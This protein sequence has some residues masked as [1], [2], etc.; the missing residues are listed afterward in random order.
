MDLPLIQRRNLNLP[1]LLMLT[2]GAVAAFLVIYPMLNLILGSLRTA[3][4][5]EPGSFTLKNYIDAFTSH[6]I[7]PT[8]INTFLIMI[9][10]TLVSC[11]VGILLVW[12]TTR[13]DTPFRRQL[14]VLNILPFLLSPYVAG[15]AWS[16]LLS[17]RIGVL[18]KFLMSL[19][20]LE[21]APF[22]IFTISGVIW[23]L[24]LYYTPYMYLFILGSF[25]AMDPSMEE[26]ARI[27]GS[28]LFKTTLKITIP[29]AAPAII[30][31]CIIV[32]VHCAGQFGVPAH[33][34][35]PKGQ[36]VL[37][38]TIMR[39]TQVYPQQYN[40]AAAVSMLLL[41]IS[42]VGIFMQR[43][44]IKGRE[45]TTVTGK[46]FRPRLILLGRWKYATLSFNI[47]YLI[48]SIVFPYGTLLVVSFLSYWSGDISTEMLTMENYR[49]VLF[50]DEAI[51]RAIKN[52][53]FVSTVG[54]FLCL[55]MTMLV[56]YLVNRT[57]VRGRGFFDYITM[58]PVGIP[59]MVVAVGL[60]WAWIRSPIPVYGTIWIIMI[61]FIT[62]YIPYGM[63]AFSNSLLQLGPELEESARICGSSWFKTFMKILI[64]LLKPGFMAGWVL[65]FI[66]FMRELSTAIV[67]WYSGNEVISVQL[68]Q[69]V[70][71]GEFTAVAALSIIQAL[72]IL[73][74]IMLFRLIVKEEFS[75]RLRR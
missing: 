45:Y 22:D 51:V 7:I 32:F 1:V 38:T 58:L 49:V 39:F 43:R 17:P 31:G 72:L 28:S 10:T 29:L 42:A 14:E 59:G 74:G 44:Y 70:R 41:V 69:L 36:Y 9:G 21:D 2:A 62:R 30:S 47:L 3:M 13:T 48:M 35:M 6:K 55:V 54:A 5:G 64:P 52:S 50:E 46:A 66:L 33:L 34:I 26:S 4:P 40:A 20:H 68:F 60:L 73:A 37:T 11:P 24:T 67:L 8:I 16:L 53:I 56:A 75:E 71:D 12:I 65:L 25:K 27:C 19:F 61:A 23:V 15:I 63:R 57:K 18:N